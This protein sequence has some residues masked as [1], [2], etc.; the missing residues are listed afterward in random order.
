[1]QNLVGTSM[2]M[3][4]LDEAN[5]L[6]RVQSVVGGARV[7]GSSVS[8]GGG[9]WCRLRGRIYAKLACEALGGKKKSE[10]NS[11]IGKRSM[12]KGGEAQVVDVGEQN[13]YCGGNIMPYP[14][15]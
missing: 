3:E 8:D 6:I 2:A 4:E 11:W 15:C 12:Y 7:S 9:I 10:T 14:R 1:M 5:D 13:G